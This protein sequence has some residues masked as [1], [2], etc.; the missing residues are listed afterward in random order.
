M[1]SWRVLIIK[2]CFKLPRMHLSEYMCLVSHTK[3]VWNLSQWLF[4]L[5]NIWR[6]KHKKAIYTSQRNGS[7]NRFV[8]SWNEQE[9]S[10][11]ARERFICESQSSSWPASMCCIERLS[12][13]IRH[14]QIVQCYTFKDLSYHLRCYHLRRVTTFK[15]KHISF[16]LFCKGLWQL[17]DR[18]CGLVVRVPGYRSGSPGFDSRYYQKK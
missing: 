18:L 14:C 9:S 11:R 7:A 4:E 13:W 10:L 5:M 3:D 8:G 15:D 16:Q 12:N 2:S 6:H 17:H 1:Q